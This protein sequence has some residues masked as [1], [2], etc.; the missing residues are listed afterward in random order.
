MNA[1]LKRIEGFFFRPISASG[2]GLMRIAWAATV[3]IYSLGQLMDVARYYGSDGILPPSIEHIVSREPYRY[4]LFD[5]VVDPQAVV[6]VY[7]IML[8]ACVYAI[9]GVY[10]RL[11]TIVAALLLFSFH[12]RNPLS[13]G[14][15]DTVLRN[16]GFLLMLA[17]CGR[18]FSKRRWRLQWER[19]RTKLPL[20]PPATMPA[21]PMWLMLWQLMVIYITT[22]WDKSLGDMWLN[23]TA[24]GSALLHTHFARWPL[25]WMMVIAVGSPIYTY[26]TL[27]WE[28]AWALLLLPKRILEALK[29]SH[30]TVKRGLLIGGILFHGGI[31]I[32]M[33]VGS[34]SPAMLTAYLGV[35]TE[36][37]FKALRSWFNNIWLRTKN[38]K[39]KTN[40]PK[41]AILY[42]GHCGLCQRSVFTLEMLDH[43]HR[44]RPVDFHDSEQKRKIA[45]DIALKDL[46]RAMHIKL[47][48]GRTYQ[49]FYAARVLAWHLPVFWLLAPFLYLP[50]VSFIGNNVYKRI[51]RNRRKCTHERCAM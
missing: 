15:G 16:A 10:P 36:E 37:D 49:G 29:L 41:I 21:W 27:I 23:G 39:P 50:G 25:S 26:G 2:F 48:D 30:G 17:P 32:L 3:L 44:L 4:T 42:D 18:A 14:G 33:D 11:M 20:L 40:K 34:F 28:F 46:N 7:V 19:W 8:I 12:E 6:I 51:A 22:A 13:L 38:Q 1:I 31:F 45:S 47:P 9:I 24:V 43:L 35:L 5:Y